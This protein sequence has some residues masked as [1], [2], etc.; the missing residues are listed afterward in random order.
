M[1]TRT[2]IAAIALGLI[3]ALT[4]C[5]N[6]G[7]SAMP[8]RPSAPSTASAPADGHATVVHMVNMKFDQER[9]EVDAGTTVRWENQDQTAHSVYEG[10]P[11]SGKY[12]FSSANL[13]PG[14]SF[15][16]RFDKPGT[17]EIFCNTGSHYLIGMKMS[18][19]VK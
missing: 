8:H 16:H 9:L 1:I 4:G 14:K 19:V 18:V 12:L 6:N 17:Y 15:S 7:S 2:A 11:A 5:S 13:T 3:A 10:V